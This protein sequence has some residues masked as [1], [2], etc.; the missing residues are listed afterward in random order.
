M[1]R[2]LLALVSLMVL[3]LS[4]EAQQKRLVLIEEFTN[5]GCGPCASWSPLLDS[6][7]NY[8]LG[9]CIAIKYHSGYPYNADEFFNYDKDAQQTRLNYYNVTGVPATFIDGIELV[10][11]SYANLEQAI[12]YC[13][14]QPTK[15][16]L[17]VSKVLSNDHK[18]K[19]EAIMTPH[20][21]MANPNLRLFVAAIEEHIEAA[22]PYPNGETELNYTMRKLFTGG[23]GYTP[24]DALTAGQSYSYQGEWD[25][26]FFDDEKQLGVLAFV[27]DLSTREVLATAYI[28]PNAEGENRLALMNL[29]DTPDQIC[30]PDYYGKA[31]FRNDGAGMVTSATLNVKVN[32]SVKQYPWT[33]QLNYLDRDTLTFGDFKDFS[34][35]AEGNNDVELWFSNINGTDAT[36]NHRFSKFSNSIQAKNNVQLRIYTDKKP[37]EITWKLYDSAGDIVREGGPY[38]EARKFITIPLE[39]TKDDCYLLEFLDAGGNGIKGANGNGYYQL[40]EV[41]EAGKTTRIAQGDYDGSVFDLFFNLSGTPKPEPKAQRLVLFEEFTNTSCDPCAEF[42]P[43]FDQLL[44]EHLGQMVA[45]TYHYNFPSNRDPFYLANPEEVM[46][47]ANYYGISGVP[48]LFVD[49]E[50]ASAWGYE[51]FLPK[52]LEEAYAIAPKVGLNTEA[53]LNDGQLKVN[54]SL[55]PQEITNGS[56]L[57]LFV[58]VVEERIEWNESAPNG[59]RSWNYVMRKML[60][61]ADGLTLESDLTKATPYQYEFDWTVQ[62]FT[63]ENELGLLTFVQDVRTQEILATT[64]TPRPTGHPQAAKILQITNTPA[65]ICSS[66]FTSDL[67][68]RNTGREALTSMN[69]NVKINGTV[70]TTPWKGKLDYLE[71][72]TLHTPLFSNFDLSETTNEVE[73]WLSDL[74]GTAEQSVSKRLS[75]ANAYKAQYAVRLTLMT[76]QLPEETTWTLFNSAGDIVEQG[77][78]YTEARKKMVHDFQL[79]T[80]DCYTLEFQDKGGNGITGEYGRGYYMLHEVS[81]E[82]KTRL[83]VQ[84]DFTTATHEVPFSLQN[85]KTT[86]ITTIETTETKSDSPVYDLQG[87]KVAIPGKGLYIK[88]SKIITN[89]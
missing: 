61:N 31:I 30:M 39:L 1:R 29:I 12:S 55:D 44:Q 77:G 32:G 59:E 63:D 26:D 10:N 25:I 75:I 79:D 84:S 37:E 69:I 7:I 18:L 34:L 22:A 74:N 78:P 80:D 86:A 15:C 46:T 57:R 62:N 71:I 45:L 89:K 72:D 9:D 2:L 65:R 17:S 67:I 23:N 47:R 43:F 64:Y 76:D 33:G 35:V 68:V 27:Q 60:P 19:V 56:N 13:L 54:V 40:M 24:G 51:P 20:T 70:Q 14:L 53:E 85:A 49:G 52:Y 66:A 6:C 81:P 58:A 48:V 36:S 50:H 83:L 38:A 21:D 28:G 11:R 88:D 41:D 8:R 3:Q 4:A 82:G 73:I 87:R 42:S 16:D 5:T